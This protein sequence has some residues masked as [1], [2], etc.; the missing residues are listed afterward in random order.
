MKKRVLVVLDMDG[1]VTRLPLEG[2]STWWQLDRYIEDSGGQ[3]L[4]A[5]NGL[6]GFLRSFFLFKM[7]QNEGL[8]PEEERIWFELSIYYWA[9][10]GLTEHDLIACFSKQYVEKHIRP[11]TVKFLRWLKKERQDTEVFVVINSYGIKQL[12]GCVLQSLGVAGLVDEIY[13][14][15]LT[16][17][18]DQKISWYEPV[19]Y[20]AP[21][22]KGDWTLQAMERYQV[23][24]CNAIGIGDSGGDRLIVPCQENRILLAG[25]QQH[26]DRYGQE[27]GRFVISE[28][29]GGMRKL[30]EDEFGL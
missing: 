5:I 3:G 16:F 22:N 6:P 28:D 30:L 2:N 11:G 9:W 29:W 27:F 17:D 20:V 14:A 10:S 4:I 18:R 23:S 26:A 25:D 1:T 8:T 19:S 24:E 7:K 13:A 15:E 12:I 21:Y